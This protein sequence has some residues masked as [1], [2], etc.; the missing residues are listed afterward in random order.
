MPITTSCWRCRGHASGKVPHPS[1]SGRFCERRFRANGLTSRSAWRTRLYGQVE[2]AERPGS[3]SHL[4]V[5]RHQDAGS[6][7]SGE[8]E[9]QRIGRTQCHP[10]RCTRSV[11]SVRQNSPLS[12]SCR[13][14]R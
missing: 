14:R 13:A 1:L 3:R 9:V 5:E 10:T 2:R 7:I 12:R 4:S 11:G 8:R 6:L